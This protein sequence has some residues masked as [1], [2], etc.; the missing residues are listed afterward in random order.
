MVPLTQHN[1]GGSFF[2][3]QSI[4]EQG[5]PKRLYKAEYQ[6]D[7]V[8]TLCFFHLRERTLSHTTTPTSA[9]QELMWES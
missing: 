3:Q 8:M 6:Q 4:T 7:Q 9:F 1:F 5:A 2:D